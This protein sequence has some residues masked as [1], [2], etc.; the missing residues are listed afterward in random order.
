MDWFPNASFLEWCETLPITAIWEEILS[1]LQDIRLTVSGEETRY[2]ALDLTGGK[3]IDGYN[4]LLSGSGE[5]NCGHYLD[6]DREN[7]EN[8]YGLFRFDLTPAEVDIPA[9]WYPIERVTSTCTW[10][11]VLQLLQF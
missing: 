1:I 6:I 4:T 7:W 9:I 11:L 10:S 8:G 2:S 5:M 3:K